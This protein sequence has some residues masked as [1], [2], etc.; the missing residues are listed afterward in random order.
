MPVDQE[1]FHKKTEEFDV[2]ITKISDAYYVF[3]VEVDGN[4]KN[5]QYTMNKP[6]FDDQLT[7]NG[8]N[9]GQLVKKLRLAKN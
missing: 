3:S 1:V 8:Y 6:T 7:K 4:E 5:Y 2:K 9:Y